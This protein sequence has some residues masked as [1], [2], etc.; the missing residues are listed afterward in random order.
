VAWVF[1]IGFSAWARADAFMTTSTLAQLGQVLD[2][3]FRAVRPCGFAP[4]SPS[5]CLGPVV[6]SGTALSPEGAAQPYLIRCGRYIIRMTRHGEGS[7]P[8]RDGPS[9]LHPSTGRDLC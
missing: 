4:D 1:R 9:V 8:N 2:A 5:A 3:V 6:Y 7:T